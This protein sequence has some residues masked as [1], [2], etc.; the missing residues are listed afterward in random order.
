MVSVF[1][2]SDRHRHSDLQFHVTYWAWAWALEDLKSGRARV[3]LGLVE[4]MWPPSLSPPLFL[5]FSSTHPLIILI[6]LRHKIHPQ[7][8]TNQKSSHFLHICK[9]RPIF[10]SYGGNACP[11]GSGHLIKNPSVWPKCAPM[12]PV[13]VLYMVAWIPSKHSETKN[14]DVLVGCP[15]WHESGCQE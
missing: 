3:Q 1:H 14:V 4:E 8:C 7:T 2:K 10:F 15:N 13:C 5:I 9:F 12:C 11:D 6:L